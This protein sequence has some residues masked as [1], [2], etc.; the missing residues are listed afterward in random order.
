MKRHDKVLE[1]LSYL[2]SSLAV[3]ILDFFIGPPEKE[4]S[5]TAILNDNKDMYIRCLVGVLTADPWPET[6]I[7]TDVGTTL[8]MNPQRTLRY[9]LDM[10]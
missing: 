4:N 2:K 9:G 1:Y 6:Y 5:C 8:A 3:V 7:Y 10:D